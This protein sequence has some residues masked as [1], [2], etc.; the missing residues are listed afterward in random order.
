MNFINNLERL[1]YEHKMNRSD[2][3][4]VTGLSVSTVK[5]ADYFNITLDELVNGESPQDNNNS[6]TND[7][8]SQVRRLLAY[9][10]KL[11]DLEDNKDA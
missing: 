3:A 1:L 4:R 2:L 8:I 6:L 11:K 7:E 9:A 10:E 5:I